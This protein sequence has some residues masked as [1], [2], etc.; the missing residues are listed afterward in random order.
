LR[1]SSIWKTL[2][3][4][5]TQDRIEI[6]RAYARQ[7]KLTNPEDDPEGF[8]VLRAAYEQALGYAENRYVSDTPVA[9]FAEPPREVAEPEPSVDIT[10]SAQS[11]ERSAPEV[12]QATHAYFAAFALLERQLSPRTDADDG[13]RKASLDIILSSPV[14]DNIET[15]DS[16]EQWLAQ[17]AARSQP[18]S[19][20]L[21]PRLVERFGWNN[22]HLDRRRAYAVSQ[23]L[24]RETDLAFL[25]AVKRSDTSSRDAW[26]TLSQPPKTPSIWK[27]LWPDISRSDILSFLDRVRSQHPTLLHDL[28]EEAV[29]TWE[30]DVPIRDVFDH[31]RVCALILLPFV[32]LASAYVLI[33]WRSLMGLIPILAAFPV[34]SVGL[35]YAYDY[36]YHRVRARWEESWRLQQNKWLAF[37]WGPALI[38]I[39]CLATLPPSPW[40]CGCIAILSLAVVWWAA[41]SGQA[42]KNVSSGPWQLRVVFAE[43][44][45]VIWWGGALWDF[46]RDAAIQMT[47]A[48]IAATLVS[49]FGQVPLFHKWLRLGAWI[50][51]ATLVT[52]IAGIAGAIALLWQDYAIGEWK[53]PAFVCA[54]IMILLHRVPT[55][56]VAHWAAGFRNTAGLVALF[57]ARAGGDAEGSLAFAGSALLLLAAFNCVLALFN[58]WRG[59]SSE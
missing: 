32:A 10:E 57:I 9:S 46:P 50:Q 44:L 42:D 1:P 19:D 38:A 21:I 51:R 28:N 27:R 12:D 23:V 13:D 39:L 7:L 47:P 49:G 8:K 4:S 18:R 29:R 56:A 11:E 22:Q 33:N 59:Q 5:R 37:G 30:A 53:A 45:L 31:I 34:A 48:V 16:A 43:L 24:Q 26:R 2:G 6:R 52:I 14:L 55:I 20:V 36:G 15:R 54:A 3:L 40:L 35:A 58:T 41:V 17:L 25:M